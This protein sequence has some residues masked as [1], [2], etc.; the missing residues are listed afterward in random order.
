MPLFFFLSG[1]FF[2]SSHEKKGVWLLRDKAA[3]IVYPYL[4]WSVLQLGTKIMMSGHTNSHAELS[5][6]MS[7]LWRPVEQFWF[8]YALFLIFCF[9]GLLFTLLERM[10]L[11]RDRQITVI[12]TLSLFLFFSRNLLPGIF[13]LQTVAHYLVYFVLGIYFSHHRL[14]PLP[15]GQWRIFLPGIFLSASYVILSTGFW[16]ADSSIAQLTLAIT[17]IGSVVVLIPS[18]GSRFAAFA[19]WLG[20]YSMEIYCC[21][22]L[23]ASGVRIILQH[24]LA[25][26]STVAHLL[27]GLIAG[28]FL[29]VLFTRFLQKTLVKHYLFTVPI[30]T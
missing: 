16:S 7:I 9:S 30:A 12:I 21:H 23:A 8:L 29:P 3:T 6:I 28:L 19:A 22:I 17:G 1:L 5:D 13:Q 10:K 18:P 26:D 15:S 11:D 14:R 4:L 20:R 24:F 2:L 27:S 25:I